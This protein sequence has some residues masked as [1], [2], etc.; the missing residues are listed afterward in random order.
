MKKRRRN[1]GSNS[2]ESIASRTLFL[3]VIEDNRMESNG[4]SLINGVSLIRNGF[5]VGRGKLGRHYNPDSSAS[6]RT[7]GQ[8]LCIQASNDTHETRDP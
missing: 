8:A 7:K 2:I 6:K 3:E 5:I 4:L 1:I